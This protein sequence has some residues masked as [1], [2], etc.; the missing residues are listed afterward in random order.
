[1][2]ESGIN[3]DQLR[4]SIAQTEETLGLAQEWLERLHHLADHGKQSAASAEL[5]QVTVLLGE[6]RAKLERAANSLG[7]AAPKDDVTVELV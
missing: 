3:I 2:C 4:M 1:M 6:A 5:A 7:G